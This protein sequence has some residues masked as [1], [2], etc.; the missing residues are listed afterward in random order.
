M[1]GRDAAL[2]RCGEAGRAE[3][4]RAGR[5]AAGKGGPL[6]GGG[7]LPSISL[8]APRR[9]RGGPGGF[10]RGPPSSGTVAPRPGGPAPPPDPGGGRPRN[11]G[12]EGPGAALFCRPALFPAAG[13]PRKVWARGAGGA[14]GRL[15]LFILPSCHL[16]GFISLASAALLFGILLFY[17]TSRRVRFSSLFR[18]N[19]CHRL[20]YFIFLIF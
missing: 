9:A 17:P 14:R 3:P 15:S 8:R 18:S 6:E 2:K 20:F 13:R 1:A 16:S 11:L 12:G 5:P 7:I 19:H 4:S 10:L